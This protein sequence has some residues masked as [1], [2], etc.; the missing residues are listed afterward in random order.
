MSLEEQ[1]II[2]ATVREFTQNELKPFASK[3][4]SDG[5]IPNHL[6]EKLASIGLFGILCS[7][8]YGG[9]GAGVLTMARA[10]TQLAQGCASTALVLVNHSL[11]CYLLNEFGDA[12]QKSKLLP[13]MA[14]G[15]KIGAIAISEGISSL[16]LNSIRT[17]LTKD[18]DSYIVSGT[19]PY[20]V[21]GSFADVYIVLARISS[22]EHQF[23]MVENGVNGFVRGESIGMLGLKAAGFSHLHF[24][25]VSITIGGA[26]GTTEDSSTILRSAQEVMWL[27]VGG[28]ALG[29]AKAALEAATK[30]ANERIQ[31][32]KQIGRFEAIQDMISQIYTDV[33]STSS[34]LDRVSLLKDNKKSIWKEAVAAK[35]FS[36]NM[37][38]RSAK[39]ALKIHGGYGFIK[40]YPV[41]RFVRDARATEIIGDRNEELKT[42]SARTILGYEEKVV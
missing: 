4:D 1:G 10:A 24:N 25:R 26:L 22:D 23:L 17:S 28:V 35:V 31:F 41:E 20:V 21:N 30:Y 34:L 18:D 16:D 8:E 33:E 2:Q 37:A 11:T 13:D 12:E 40:D 19:K 36:T 39:Y 9:V 5:A 42:A 7:Q 3:I 27:G 14:S 38:T 15:K 32:G 29:I 6:V